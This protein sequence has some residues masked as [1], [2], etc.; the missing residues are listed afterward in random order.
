M[1]MFQRGAGMFNTLLRPVLGAPVVGKFL[2][3]S[4]AEVTY[5]GRKS[6]RR[7][8]LLVSYKRRGDEVLIAVAMP[9]KK[10]WWR[11]FYPDGS[12]IGIVLDGVLRTGR[13]LARKDGKRVTVKV[14][15]DPIEQA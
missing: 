13:A 4:L 5:V 10:T 8:E 6:G 12:Q 14:E 9:D 15:L 2:S 1:S 7:V 3:G 11:N